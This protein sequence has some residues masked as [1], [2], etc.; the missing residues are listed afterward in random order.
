MDP[1]CRGREI[2]RGVLRTVIKT[3][4]SVHFLP[5]ERDRDCLS[6]VCY[7]RAANLFFSQTPTRRPP[8]ITSRP[9]N[10]VF[11]GWTGAPTERAQLEFM[12]QS[13]VLSINAWRDL[14]WTTRV[15]GLHKN[16]TVLPV[17]NMRGSV[18][19]VVVSLYRTVWWDVLL[20]KESYCCLCWS[21]R[22][23]VPTCNL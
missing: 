12:T 22:C 11:L 2:A 21:D 18:I 20:A 23:T 4:K 16:C 15:L 10:T 6:S 5:L 19:G 1:R 7:T 17:Q 8:Y 9:V 3:F 13:S 14:G